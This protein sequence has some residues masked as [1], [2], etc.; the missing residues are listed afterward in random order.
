MEEGLRERKKRET[1][2]TIHDTAMRLF[3]ERGFAEVSVLEIA[4]QAGVSKMTVFN[5]FPTKEDIV[6]DVM[7][8]SYSDIAQLVSGRRPG[9]SLVDGAHREF[10]ERL[11]RHAPET[12][13]DDSP[14]YLEQLHL[15]RKTPSLA[16]RLLLFH[17]AAE[18][19]MTEAIE[20]ERP[21]DPRAPF[22]AGQ[23]YSLLRTLQVQNSRRI[24]HGQSADEAYPDALAAADTGFDL[25]RG[26]L[27]D[28]LA[29]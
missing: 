13:L 15:F 14:A 21:G 7:G 18:A 28:Y 5:Y 4:E 20:L 9:E 6:L 10:V 23:L 26:G 22:A 19:K 8:E 3:T 2:R 12:G 17:V 24:Y 29:G 25:L 16:A 11:A 1:R 27:G